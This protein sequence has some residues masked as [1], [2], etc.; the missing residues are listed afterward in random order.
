VTSISCA[1][2]PRSTRSVTVSPGS[3]PTISIDRSVSTLICSP[4][5]ATITSPACTPAASA[6]LPG[7]TAG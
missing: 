3:W 4:S 5:T 6:G 7:M 2:L 1:E